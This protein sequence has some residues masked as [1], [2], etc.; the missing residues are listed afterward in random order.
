MEGT[1]AVRVAVYQSASST[2][3]PIE[4]NAWQSTTAAE[5]IRRAHAHFHPDPTIPAEVT[6]AWSSPCDLLASVISPAASI[7]Y[8]AELVMCLVRRLSC[9]WSAMG[10]PRH[11]LV[12]T[13]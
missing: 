1:S 6:Y 12:T 2:T 3:N 8:A 4:L 13:S 5:L 9:W 11:V 7:G 10:L